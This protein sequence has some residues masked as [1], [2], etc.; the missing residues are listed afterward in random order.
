MDIYKKYLEEDV[1][2]PNAQQAQQNVTQTQ[3]SAAQA[4]QAQVVNQQKVQNQAKS[5][6]NTIITFAKSVN[7]APAQ[8][9]SHVS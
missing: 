1:A 2:A 6:A 5:M 8:I 4:Q 7:M 3:Q 9:Y